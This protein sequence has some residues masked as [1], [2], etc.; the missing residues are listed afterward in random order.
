LQEIIK[1]F[2]DVDELNFAESS[3]LVLQIKSEEWFGEFI[4]VVEGSHI[5]DWSMLRITR[6]VQEQ[7]PQVAT[8][9]FLLIAMVCSYLF[10]I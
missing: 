8:M 3:E 6:D 9:A 1:P 4:D 10:I 5:P 2:S 7:Q